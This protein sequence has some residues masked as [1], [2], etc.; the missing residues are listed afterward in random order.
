MTLTTLSIERKGGFGN[1]DFLGCCPLPGGEGLVGDLM[2]DV[3]LDKLASF[4]C[5]QNEFLL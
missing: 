2:I 3:S 4:Y 1:N 5:Y